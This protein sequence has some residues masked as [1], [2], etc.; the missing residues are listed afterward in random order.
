[1]NKDKRVNLSDFFQKGFE[2]VIN[3]KNSKEFLSKK[4]DKVR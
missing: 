2:K 4:M 3:K 1:M